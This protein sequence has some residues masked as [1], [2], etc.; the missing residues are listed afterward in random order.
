MLGAD[1][2]QLVGILVGIAVFAAIG[3]LSGLKIKTKADYYIAGQS[4][5][6]VSVASSTAGMFIGGGCVIGTAQ[7]AF[8]DGFSGVAFTASLPSSVQ[9]TSSSPVAFVV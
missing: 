5:G 2:M 6:V 1:S 8:T 9:L 4:F 7:L 3:I